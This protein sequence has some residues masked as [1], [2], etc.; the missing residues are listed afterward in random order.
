MALTTCWKLLHT[1][2]Y[3]ELSSQSHHP[4][5]IF[6]G[7]LYQSENLEYVSIFLLAKSWERLAYI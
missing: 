6:L 5:Y 2:N 1:H 7:F 3:W 4:S